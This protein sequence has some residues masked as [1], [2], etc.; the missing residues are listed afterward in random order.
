ME[1]NTNLT[2]ICV[3]GSNPADWLICGNHFE[4]SHLTRYEGVG[5]FLLNFAGTLIVKRLTFFLS[6]QPNLKES[7][8]IAL[9]IYNFYQGSWYLI[10]VIWRLFCQQLTQLNTLHAQTIHRL[11]AVPQD[12]HTSKEIAW[13]ERKPRGSWGGGGKGS[14]Q[15][16]SWPIPSL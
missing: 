4:Q 2:A 15:F 1:D 14:L 5:V 8:T 13:S 3:R 12:G 16:P 6:S 9:L 7:G 10:F 11:P